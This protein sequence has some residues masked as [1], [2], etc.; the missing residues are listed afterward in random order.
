MRQTTESLCR[1]S[2]RRQVEAMDKK[3]LGTVRSTISSPRVKACSIC[4]SVTM[5]MRQAALILFAPRFS[6][7][8]MPPAA[9]RC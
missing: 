7:R 5:M 4:V 1:F 3:G 2:F 8:L 6:S 9:L